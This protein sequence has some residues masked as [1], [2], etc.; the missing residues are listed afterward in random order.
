MFGFFN[1]AF[2][3][4]A[5]MT[6]PVPISR[7]RMRMRSDMSHSITMWSSQWHKLR[8]AN[9]RIPR[10]QRDLV[11]DA[12][13]SNQFISRITAEIQIVHRTANVECDGPSLQ[14]REETRQ[15]NVIEVNLNATELCEL[16]D[17]PN[18]NVRD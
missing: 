7:V 17:F 11:H 9:L 2:R 1:T 6:R 3:I 10:Q 8:L 15:F 4:F 13:G 12:R 18:D 16:P 5:S 14:A